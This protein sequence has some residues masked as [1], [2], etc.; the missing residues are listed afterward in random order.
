MTPLL[1]PAL[2]GQ[3]GQWRYYQVVMRVGEIVENFGNFMQPN[4][5]IKTVEEVEEIYSRKGVSYLLQREFDIKRL[6]PLKTYITSQ[7]DKYLNNLT[8]AIFGGSPDWQPIDVEPAL[9]ALKADEDTAESFRDTF[10][11]VR[12]SG[13]ETLFVLDGQHRLK[14]LREA[15]LDKPE[16]ENEQIAITLII[17]ISTDA[18]RKRTRRLFSTINRHAKPVSKGENILLDEDDLSAIITRSLIEDYPLIKGK[19]AIAQN[20]TANL[21]QNQFETAL[22]TVLAVYEINEVL[23]KED[24]IYVN[25]KVRIR[26]TDDIIEAETKKVFAFWDKFFELFPLA[27]KFVKGDKSIGLSRNGGGP[28]YMRPI[29]QKI[30][31]DLY[32][33]L[34]ESNQ[35]DLISLVAKIPADVQNK[36]WHF[37]LWNPVKKTVLQNESLAKSYLFYHFGLPQSKVVIKALNDNYAKNAGDTSLRIGPSLNLISKNS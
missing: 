21:Y 20:K 24:E 27:V 26:P 16:L 8:V 3:F 11:A 5:R 14:G 12:L 15:I 34:Y 25:P 35:L 2:T 29:G 17:H 32:Q 13:Y 23:L 31:V 22:T 6:I 36:F 30:V 7:P 1:L 10:G 37:I 19:Q 18:G 28:F 33:I 4:Y 9:T